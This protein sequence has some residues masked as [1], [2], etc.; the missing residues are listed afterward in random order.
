MYLETRYN[1][2][3]STSHGV[4]ARNA[5]G[6]DWL[7]RSD[8]ITYRT[9]GGSFDFYFLSGESSKEVIS[10]YQ[11]QIVGTPFLQPYWTLGFG[12]NRWGYQNW[13][14]LQDVI[15][16]YADQRIQLEMIINDLDYLEA[17]RIFTNSPSHYPHQQGVEF[18]DKLHASG[19]Y[20]FP[21]LDP[22]VYAPHPTNASG[23]YEIYDRG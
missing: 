13:T 9:I 18:L 12:Q 15:D 7:L 10:Q 19:Q 6:Q 21:I 3:G 17:N 2:T 22:I 5:N 20:W 4:Y 1:D 23:S 8:N 14:N 16:G 11:T